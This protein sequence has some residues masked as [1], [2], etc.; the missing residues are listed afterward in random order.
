MCHRESACSQNYSRG[1]VLS[2]EVDPIAWTVSFP[3]K[4]TTSGRYVMQ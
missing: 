4:W 2:T 3:V 1:L